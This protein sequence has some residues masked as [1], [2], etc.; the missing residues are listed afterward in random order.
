[1]PSGASKSH[2]KRLLVLTALSVSLVAGAAAPAWAFLIPHPEGDAVI[3]RISVGPNYWAE[4]YGPAT[5]VLRGN[6]RLVINENGLDGSEPEVHRL[7][8]TEQG[9]QIVLRGARDAHLFDGSTDYGEAQ[10]TDQGTTSVRLNAAGEHTKFA[11]Y[12]LD[13]PAGDDGIDPELLSERRALRSFVED[14]MRP[15]FYED[16]RKA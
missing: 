5:L 2:M 10:V 16:V 13:L 14:V 4:S 8:L 1:V 15:S 12:A 6:G 11:V 7:R 3:L 9:V